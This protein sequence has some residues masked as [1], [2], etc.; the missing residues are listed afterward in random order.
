[1]ATVRVSKP[2]VVTLSTGVVVTLN[3]HDEYDT[4]DLVVREHKW[5][6]APDGVERATARP[7]ELRNR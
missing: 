2:C 7:G 5:A 4:S 6:F 3:M 1:M